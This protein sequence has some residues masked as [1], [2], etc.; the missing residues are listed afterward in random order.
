MRILVCASAA[1]IAPFDGMRTQLHALIERLARQHEVTV[2]APR[3]PDQLGDPPAGLDTRWIA[4]PPTGGPALAAQRARSLARR[5]PIDAVRLAGPMSRA[6]AA[7]V[8]ERRFDVAHVGLGELAGLAPVLGTLPA[9]LAPLD[10]WSVNV[11][12]AVDAARGLRRRWL[13][14]QQA[15][16]AGHVA[17]AYRPFRAVVLVSE[18]DAAETRRLD[19]DAGH[20]GHPQ[21]RRHRS[22]RP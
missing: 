1:P 2:V 7:V 13:L 17:H 21:R 9:V 8:A 5:T 11:G 15:L 14:H 19:S 4:P 12:A 16:V 18:E 6:V 20:R 10:A 3:W 22:L